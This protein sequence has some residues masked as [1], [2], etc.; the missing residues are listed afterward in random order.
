MNFFGFGKKGDSEHSNQIVVYIDRNLRES[1]KVEVK[2]QDSIEDVM[3]MLRTQFQK[4]SK[5]Y[6]QVG[7]FKSDQQL[8]LQV[9]Q[10]KKSQVVAQRVLFRYEKPSQLREVVQRDGFYKIEFFLSP[11]RELRYPPVTYAEPKISPPLPQETAYELQGDLQKRDK[12]DKYKTKFFKL[13]SDH[14]IYKDN[15]KSSEMNYIPL[16]SAQIK[17]TLQSNFEFQI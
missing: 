8:V 5:I 7:E 1:V 17:R 9:R 11:N 2:Q 16:D 10:R 3:D 6:S 15:S 12:N 13:Y 14:I 4:N